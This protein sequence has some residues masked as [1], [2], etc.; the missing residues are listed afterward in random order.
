MLLGAL[1]IVTA[2][3]PVL[4]P[5]KFEFA[6]KNAPVSA[7]HWIAV[8]LPLALLMLIAAWLLNPKKQIPR[9]NQKG[10]QQDGGEERR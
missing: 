6:T 7:Q 3:A 9:Q 1:L 4:N 5:G 2:L 8:T 10:V